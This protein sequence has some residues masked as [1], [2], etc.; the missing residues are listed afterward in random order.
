[1]R[2]DGPVGYDLAA[3]FSAYALEVLLEAVVR[4]RVAYLVLDDQQEHRSR[5]ERAQKERNGRHRG[6][7]GLQGDIGA[8]GAAGLA[9][10]G[11]PAPPLHDVVCV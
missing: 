3:D 7:H 4:H 6:V 10:V 9:P 11:I 5:G 8:C 2:A 1:M